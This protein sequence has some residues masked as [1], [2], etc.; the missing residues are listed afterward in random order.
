MSRCLFERYNRS[1]AEKIGGDCRE[2]GTLALRIVA[3]GRGIR[4]GFVVVFF[5]SPPPQKEQQ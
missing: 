1:R 4:I 3:G 5:L 2:F